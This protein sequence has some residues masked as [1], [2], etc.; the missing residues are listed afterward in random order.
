MKK[1]QVYIA[2]PA[3]FILLAAYNNCSP[4]ALNSAPG[5]Q[6]S[7]SLSPS[8]NPVPAPMPLPT[9]PQPQVAGFGGDGTGWMLNGIAT[10]DFDVATMTDGNGSENSSMF[11]LAP[12]TFNQG[13]T[14]LFVYQDV[15]ATPNDADGGTFTIQN[16]SATVG[17]LGASGGALGYLGIQNSIAV[18]F[19]IYQ[20]S[21]IAMATNGT[22]Y[23]YMDTAPVDLKSGNPIQ[24]Q[25]TY[26]ASQQSLDVNLTDTATLDNFD[27][28]FTGV[29]LSNLLGGGTTGYVGFTGGTGGAT[30]TQ[31]ISGF[32]LFY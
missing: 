13:F 19:D 21:A 4:H 29:D 24:V 9:G 18:A 2:L 10:V 14:A 15:G 32:S 27:Y 12:V 26:D 20:R 5:A 8:P 16:S 23:N 30:S 6:T 31:T 17:A 11:M 1:S 28:V 7:A 25:L 22:G 3:L